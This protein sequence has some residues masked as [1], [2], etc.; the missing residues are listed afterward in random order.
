MMARKGGPADTLE[1]Q[2][3]V[4]HTEFPF[5]GD[6]KIPQSRMTKSTRKHLL[7][8]S[9]AYVTSQKGPF[10]LCVSASGLQYYV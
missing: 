2:T 9:E 3:L 4:C 8:I 1:N 6:V 7:P 10:A 5:G